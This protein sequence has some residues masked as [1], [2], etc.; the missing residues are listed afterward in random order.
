MLTSAQLMQELEPIATNLGFRKSIRENSIVWTHPNGQIIIPIDLQL[1]PEHLLRIIRKMQQITMQ[2]YTPLTNR[3]PRSA[4]SRDR[5]QRIDLSRFTEEV[6]SKQYLSAETE[7]TTRLAEQH[8]ALSELTK[9]WLE[10]GDEQEQT[11]TWEYLRQV[12]DEDRPSN[13]PLFP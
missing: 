11:E 8:K 6:A 1:K 3:Y 12:L 13:R 7:E 5:Y 9:L 10:E 4:T 2:R